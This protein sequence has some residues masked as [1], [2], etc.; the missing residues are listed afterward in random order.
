MLIETEKTVTTRGDLAL[1]VCDH[2]SAMLAYWDKNLLCRFANAAYLEWF[3]KS[4]EE[5]IDKMTIDQL[6]GPLYQLNLPYI[7]GAL[8]GKTQTFE[9]EI[10]VPTGGIRYSIANYYPD[11]VNGEVKGFVVHVADITPV[12]LL[13]K[14][15]IRLKQLEA[16][17]KELEQF[18]YIASHDLQ[19]P[20][21][22]I[23]NIVDVVSKDYDAFLDD[24]LKNYLTV[25]DAT[26][27]KMSTLIKAVLEYS[28]IGS[29]RKIVKVDTKKIVNEVISD[30]KKSITGSRAILHIGD[31]PTL[32][33]YENELLLVFHN[34]LSNAIKFSKKDVQP[35]IWIDAV[36]ENDSWKFSVEDNGIGIDARYSERIFN[37]F[38]RLHSEFEY[39]GKGIGLA[40]CKK[41]IE[42]HGGKI[43]VESSPGKGSAF[44]FTISNLSV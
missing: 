33:A 17:N 40:V 12:K 24:T 18:T 13:E 9:R 1:L 8:E 32:Y 30:M 41:I 19:E 36:K 29:D 2:I 42:L 39:P 3:G 34:L 7:T 31:L 21:R 22:T 44:Y 27:A 16:K 6:L 25:I 23:R 10:P 35:E 28:R 5:M 15:L 14:E 20:L 4:K 38:Q 11:I 43:W 37:I 26:T